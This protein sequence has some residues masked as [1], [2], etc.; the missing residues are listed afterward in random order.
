VAQELR[1]ANL[2]SWR[3]Q[4]VTITDWKGLSAVAEFDPAFLHLESEPR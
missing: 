1:T 4:L 2:V 3:G